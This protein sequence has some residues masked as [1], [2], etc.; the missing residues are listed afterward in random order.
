MGQFIM[1]RYVQMA[2]FPYLEKNDRNHRDLEEINTE[3]ISYTASLEPLTP[4]LDSS[5]FFRASRLCWVVL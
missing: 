4:S 3:N 5:S 2:L 1:N